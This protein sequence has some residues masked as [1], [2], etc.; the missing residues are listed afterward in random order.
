[1]ATLT[2]SAEQARKAIKYGGIL[3]VVITIL[4]YLGVA[5]VGYYNK[6]YPPTP[7]SPTVDFGQLPTVVFPEN[8]ER[9]SIAFELPT[10][11]IPAFPDRMRVYR[12]PTR[13]SGFADPDKAIATATAL[14]F[15]F[16]PE[17]P[18]EVNYV[19]TL[20]DQLASK[21][22]MN[23]ISGH[24]VLTRQ[25][26]NNPTLAS[27]AN[28]SSQKAVITEVENYLKKSS[29]LPSDAIGAEKTTPLKDDVG[30]MINALSLSDADFVQLDLFRKDVEEI[31]PESS[32]KE[33][34]AKYPFY[35]TDP[36]KGL[37]RV[38]FSGGKT[39]AEKFVYINYGYTTVQYDNSGTYPIKT[40]E[41]A[42]AELASGGG[43]VTTSSPKTGEIK[44]RKIF[45]GYY[46]AED[47]QNYAMPIYIFLGDKGF[48]AY[49]S[50]VKDEWI[51][52]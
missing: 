43:F 41:E 8:K 3:F 28:F 10:G 21:L 20:Q 12:A 39:V 52:K 22:E 33:V 49:V 32:S 50:A 13:R 1:M 4:W 34:V 27:M 14:G 5:G 31:D 6:L 7:P 18:T 45:L 9:P 36:G 42:W 19:W 17:Q 25:W 16:K 24:F 30:K 11:N 26:Q 44:I 38:I 48:V 37:I 29:I 51:K 40:G 46:D 35:R 23:I 47:G 2:E 15:L